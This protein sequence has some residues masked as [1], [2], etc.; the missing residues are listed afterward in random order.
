MVCNTKQS[1]K[2]IA[3]TVYKEFVY[4]EMHKKEIKPLPIESNI[5]ITSNQHAFVG[6]KL[7][8]IEKKD[9]EEIQMKE[10]Q[11]FEKIFGPYKDELTDKVLR[12]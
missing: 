5:R 2:Q 1:F 4:C 10:N 6:L 9:T 3:P 12:K 11:T 7:F 8:S